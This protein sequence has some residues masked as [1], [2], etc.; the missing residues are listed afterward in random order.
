MQHQPE[1]AGDRVAHDPIVGTG[2]AWSARSVTST[3]LSS[4][5]PCVKRR[6]GSIAVLD[7]LL[8]GEAIDDRE[9]AA[10]SRGP[11][12]AGTKR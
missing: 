2:M 4:S 3:P 9:R 5:E 8:H 11:G 7:R 12:G 6:V 10:R 1:F